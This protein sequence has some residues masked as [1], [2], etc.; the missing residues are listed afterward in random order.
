MPDQKTSSSEPLTDKQFQIA[1]VF[2]A[3]F[4]V[5]LGISLIQYFISGSL[6]AAK[7]VGAIFS[8]WV[9]AII[10]FYFGQRPVEQVRQTLTEERART[11]ELTEYIKARSD[12]MWKRLEHEEKEG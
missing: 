7:L 9:G 2:I 10:G 3:G 8:G 6:E 11:K 4:F 1:I 5:L 12:E